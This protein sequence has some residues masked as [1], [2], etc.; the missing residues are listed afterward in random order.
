MYAELLS[1]VNFTRSIQ[2]ENTIDSLVLLLSKLWL[3]SCQKETN[4]KFSVQRQLKSFRIIVGL[5]M[6][7]KVCLNQQASLPQYLIFQFSVSTGIGM[8]NPFQPSV[9]FHIETSHLFCVGK[10][11]T[12]FYMKC[13][14][15]LK[16][17]NPFCANICKVLENI[18]INGS[19]GRNRLTQSF[20]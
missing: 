1:C 5:G 12:G 20:P 17:V 3:M 15:G 14:T 18:E 10:K 4:Q 11:M 7:E 16:Q 19:I 13:N 9:A 8:I 6:N 2:L